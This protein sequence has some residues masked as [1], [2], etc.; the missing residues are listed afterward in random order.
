VTTRA[1]ILE[2]LDVVYG[3]TESIDNIL[4]KIPQADQVEFL[5]PQKKEKEEEAEDLSKSE[6]APIIQLV[7]ALIVDAIVGSE[8]AP[9]RANLRPPLKR[10]VRFSRK[11]LS[12]ETG[13]ST[14]KRRNQVD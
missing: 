8:E 13:L 1:D 6:S 12:R 9:R 2:M 7:N 3:S 14:L 11:P 4:T 10:L 5:A